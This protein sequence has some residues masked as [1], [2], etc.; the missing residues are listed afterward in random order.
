MQNAKRAEKLS[1]E[2]EKSMEHEMLNKLSENYLNEI[3]QNR[4]RKA[5]DMR[6]LS[7]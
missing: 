2:L 4:K 1:Q 7:S 6:A 5:R 3:S